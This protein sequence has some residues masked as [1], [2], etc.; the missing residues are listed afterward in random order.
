[1]HLYRNEFQ[2]QSKF[3][4]FDY[5]MLESVQVHT[6]FMNVSSS[7]GNNTFFYELASSVVL[8][9]GYYDLQSLNDILKRT[10][11]LNYK[12]VL[13]DD[14]QTFKLWKFAG[15]AQWGTNDYTGAVDKTNIVS[16]LSKLNNQIYNNTFFSPLKLFLSAI[17]EYT[18]QR[19]NNQITTE[20]EIIVPITAPRGTTQILYFNP[21]IQF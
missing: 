12:L 1:M 10:G 13:S 8:S 9:N 3:S 14:A 21:P 17:S 15:S 18:T 4:R 5:C 11:T 19:E 7:I 6:S 16:S 20:Q 2:T